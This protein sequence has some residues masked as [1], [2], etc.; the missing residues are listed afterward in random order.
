MNLLRRSYALDP[1]VRAILET[2]IQRIL[3]RPCKEQ[4]FP[5]APWTVNEKA[6]RL[7]N[8]LKAFNNSCE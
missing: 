4:G 6:R 2:P 1:Y 8:M 5:N 7:Q 3:E